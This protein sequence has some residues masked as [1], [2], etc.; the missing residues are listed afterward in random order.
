[1]RT[2]VGIVGAGPAGLLLA[3]LMHLAGIDCVILEQR[4]RQY[5]EGRIRAGVLEQGTVDVLTD[6]GV[7]ARLEREGLI[8]GGI[9]LSLNGQRQR[10]DLAELSGGKVVTVYGQTE[11]TKDLIDANI[12]AGVEIVF[13]ALDVDLHDIAE[14]RPRLSYVKDGAPSQ[15]ECDFIAGCDGFHG[16]S[17]TRIP[18]D[19][20]RTYERIYPFAWLGILAEA[21]PVND[22]L[23]YARHDHGFALYSMRSANRCR[24]TTSNAVPDENLDELAG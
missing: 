15:L 2:Q 1:M 24:E 21:P 16:V 12:A 17:R 3:R 13:E 20:I 14:D 10:L 22:E 8:H 19:R 11:V 4:D 23:I 6:A 18:A 5:V 7:S 9:N